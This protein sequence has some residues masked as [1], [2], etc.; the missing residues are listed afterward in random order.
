MIVNYEIEARS[1]GLTRSHGAPLNISRPE[2]P[3]GVDKMSLKNS[4]QIASRERILSRFLQRNEN[5]STGLEL[6]K[7]F[8][9]GS[10]VEICRQ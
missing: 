1:E 2:I 5:P 4:A 7:L 8:S 3:G 6:R 9:G 10:K